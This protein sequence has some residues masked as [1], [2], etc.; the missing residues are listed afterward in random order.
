MGARARARARVANRGAYCRRTTVEPPVG[1]STRA[2][3]ALAHANTNVNSDPAGAG[4]WPP[5]ARHSGTPKSQAFTLPVSEGFLDHVPERYRGWST[6]GE[7]LA[8]S[9]SVAIYIKT[10]M[11]RPIAKGRNCLSSFPDM[12]RASLRD[13]LQ[14]AA[15]G[16]GHAQPALDVANHCFY[17]LSSLLFLQNSSRF[18][19][20]CPLLLLSY[21]SRPIQE[22]ASRIRTNAEMRRHT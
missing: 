8:K 4:L 5:S 10:N 19:A 20:S 11:R 21:S 17:L 13:R 16:R 12:Q 2:P 6:A 15:V 1:G 22:L 7:G 14:R 3:R 18:T 9:G